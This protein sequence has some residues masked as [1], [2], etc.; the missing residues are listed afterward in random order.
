MDKKLKLN[1]IKYIFILFSIMFAI[2]SIIYYINNRTILG[3]DREFCFLLTNN[4]KIF[5]TGVYLYIITGMIFIYY[6]MVK[7]RDKI[8][9]TDKQIFKYICIISLIFVIV[10]PFMGSDVFYYLGIGRLKSEYNKNPYYTTISEYFEQTKNEE[11]EKDTVMRQGNLNVWSGT[12]V[13][14]G[15]IWTLICSGVAKISFGNIDF[16]LLIFKLINVLVHI[17]N[18]FVIY[19]IWK[20]KSFVLM[21]GLNPFILI[22]GIANI[23]NDMFVLLFI[24]LATYMI[25]KKKDIMMS[26]VFLSLATAIKYFAVLLL[27]VFVIYYYKDKKVSERIAKGGAWVLFFVGLILIYYLP[28]IKDINVFNGLQ[29][30]QEKFAKSLYI[31]IKVLLP[32]QVGIMTRISRVA[33]ILFITIYFIKCLKL[34]TK[35]EIKIEKEMREHAIYLMLFLFIVITNF[36]PWYLIWIFYCLFWQKQENILYLNNICIIT[37]LA[38]CIFLTYSEDWRYGAIFSAIMIGAIILL[39]PTKKFKAIRKLYEKIDINEQNI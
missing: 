28:F 26:V 33:L 38:N 23:H 35:K 10:I 8:F 19:K 17:L 1:Y 11:I 5:Q 3:F 16:G 12:T 37:L 34:L 29:M 18:C 14:Y 30:Q 27:P 13:V 6:L 32:N 7:N 39:R 4:S 2:P 24:L 15:P 31:I 20:K 25:V 36:Q 21:Y 22:E 9:K